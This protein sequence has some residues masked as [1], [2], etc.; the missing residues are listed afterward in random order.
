MSLPAQSQA[1]RVQEFKSAAHV[2]EV[3]AYRLVASVGSPT[4]GMPLALYRMQAR[5]GQAAE[6]LS[7]AEAV[8]ASFA[9]ESNYPN[10]FNPETVIPFALPEAS[11]VEI[12]VYD[13][14]GRRVAVL[15]EGELAAGRHAVRFRGEDLA[16]G[17]YLVRMQA[18][19]FRAVRRMTF[20]K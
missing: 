8:P 9:L 16:S 4:Q 17:V 19:S 6:A 2:V 7:E 20:V 15:V 5:H 18:G 1:L 14:L 12:A 10:P 13:L 11:R 3:G